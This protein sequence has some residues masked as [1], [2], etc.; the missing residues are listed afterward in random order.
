M[1][2]LVIDG[3][4]SGGAVGLGVFAER[5]ISGLAKRAA[6]QLWTIEVAVSR[7]PD[8]SVTASLLNV[9]HRVL[10]V[11]RV[12]HRLLDDYLWKNRLGSWCA[13]RRTETVL[14]SPEP[15][16][17][18]QAPDRCVVVHHDCIYRHFPRYQ[19]RLVVR[20]WLTRKTERFLARCSQVI[21]ES[22]HAAEELVRLAGAPADRVLVI[23]A[24]LPPAY[25]RAAARGDAARVRARYA[26]PERYWL[27][28][29]GY[30]Y[31]KN[32]E[33]LVA[34][35]AS[36]K[37]RMSCPALV[38]AGRLPV[39]RSGSVCD[40]DGALR[41][42]GPAASA[43]SRPGFVASADMPGL[44]A[45]AELMVYPSLYEGFGLP[46]LEA[47][48][49]GCPAI[50][51]DNSSLPEVVAD[52]NYRFDACDTAA[53]ASLLERAAAQPLPF[54]PSF[55]PALFSERTAMDRYVAALTPLLD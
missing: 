16:W 31:R 34:A 12:G 17:S 25:D 3:G 14:L 33:T 39:G 55:L 52:S 23:P 44:Y 29:G 11:P 19:G 45:G 41:R 8:P 22:R 48:G 18:L 21:T 27:Y 6:E 51:A 36:V 24:W 5:L 53:L 1:R 32:V 28:V 10:G 38:L 50:V 7:V 26:L 13:R 37:N 47:M 9:R 40:V 20:R 15:F 43:I 2:T 4:R 30:D 42:A 54:N 46:P 35:Y 49:S